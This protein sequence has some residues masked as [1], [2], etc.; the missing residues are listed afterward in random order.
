MVFLIVTFILCLPL[1]LFALSNQGMVSL[2]IWPTDYAI[3][4]HLSVA[5][6]VAMAI[7]FLLGA[8]VVWFSALAQ[9]RRA[10]RAERLVRMLEAQV[11]ELKSR[12]MPP[13]SLPPG[14]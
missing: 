14:V 9:R 8:L 7:A 11:E 5:I 12:A 3:E 1:L 2:G 10:R 6:L 4:V 13:M